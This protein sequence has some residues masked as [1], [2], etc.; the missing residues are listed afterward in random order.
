MKIGSAKIEAVIIEPPDLRS[1]SSGTVRFM[2][3]S[4][5]V[6]ATDREVSM[7]LAARFELDSSG[8][9]SVELIAFDGSVVAKSVLTRFKPVE[10]RGMPQGAWPIL[11]FRIHMVMPSG[12]GRNSEATLSLD[13]PYAG[14]DVPSRMFDLLEL[15]KNLKPTVTNDERS[16]R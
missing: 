8:P 5:S 9:R 15:K 2:I 6:M 10:C 7:G 14:G 11:P 13:R 3:Q 16:S 12:T 1:S 4:V